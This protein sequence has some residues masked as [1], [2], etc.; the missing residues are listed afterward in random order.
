VAQVKKT[1]GNTQSMDDF[2]QISQMFRQGE[3]SACD[4][5]TRCQETMGAKEFARIFAEL[6]VLLPDI[7]KQQVRP[8]DGYQLWI[9]YSRTF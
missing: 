5:Y 8:L 9:V 6:L 2:C 7:E 4:F 3:I 1:L